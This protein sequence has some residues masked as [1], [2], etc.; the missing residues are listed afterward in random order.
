MRSLSFAVILLVAGVV[1]A[2][3]CSADLAPKAQSVAIERVAAMNSIVH[4]SSTLA[5]S[6]Y[7]SESS[8]GSTSVRT[9]GI[10]KLIGLVVVGLLAAGKFLMGLFTGRGGS[11]E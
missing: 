8:G 10:G 11:D 3:T 1:G 7:D 2:S 9:R 5:Q 4:A 6:S